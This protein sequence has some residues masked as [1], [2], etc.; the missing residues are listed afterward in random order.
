MDIPIFLTNGY[1][2]PSSSLTTVTSWEVKRVTTQQT[3]GWT[4]KYHPQHLIAGYMYPI[5]SPLNTESPTVM[6]LFS[7]KPTFHPTKFHEIPLNPMKSP[8]NHWNH[9]EITMKSP[10]H[11]LKSYDIL[12]NPQD[13]IRS[14]RLLGSTM[15]RSRRFVAP[16]SHPW[17]SC[18][19]TRP[20]WALRGLM[21]NMFKHEKGFNG[22]DMDSDRVLFDRKINLKKKINTHINRN[23]FSNYQQTSQ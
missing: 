8:W 13:R 17:P 4:T 6:N 5:I 12:W 16:A 9:H 1:K 22:F 11:H 15:L 2:W 3:L 21:F 10:W 23:Y 14:S 7:K 19:A 18:W 20:Q